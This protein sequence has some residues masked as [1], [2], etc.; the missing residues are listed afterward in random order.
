MPSPRLQP[1]LTRRAEL[2]VAMSGKIDYI[3][4]GEISV[5]IKNGHFYQGEITG[6]GCMASTAVATFASVSSGPRG[7]FLAAVAGYAHPSFLSTSSDSD[8]DFLRST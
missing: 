8:T 1:L 5:M 3:S 6:S 4:D 7:A 2:T